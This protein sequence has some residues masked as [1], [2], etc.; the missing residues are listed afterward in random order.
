MNTLM[1]TRRKLAEAKF[2][3]AL[4]KQVEDTGPITSETLDDE[5]TYFLSALLSAMYSVLEYLNRESKRALRACRDPR[6]AMQEALL[7]K[8]TSGIKQRNGLLYNDPG[9]REDPNERGLRSLSVHHKIVDAQHHEHTIGTWGSAPWGRL[10]FG[11]ARQ[12]RSLFVRDPRTGAQVSI[13][14][15]VTSHLHE[16]EGLVAHWEERI[17]PV[18]E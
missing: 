14:P 13:V 11:E 18:P 12:V 1:E 9:R 8:E 16:L 17:R 4:L 7:K 5:A 3:F 10:R 6:L 2:F 15:F